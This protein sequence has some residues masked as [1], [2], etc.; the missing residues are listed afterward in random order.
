M[1][2]ADTLLLLGKHPVKIALEAHRGQV[3][4]SLRRLY[5]NSHGALKPSFQGI[6]IPAAFLPEIM[7][8]LEK[9]KA[10]M[11]LDGALEDGSPP[12]YHSNAYP[13]QF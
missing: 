9:L 10:Q 7:A 3:V 2:A 5:V 8:A 11:V 12:K 6:N 13:R 4:I 1:S